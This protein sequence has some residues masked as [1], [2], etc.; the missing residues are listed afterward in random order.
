MRR[1][2]LLGAA[3]IAACNQGDAVNHTALHLDAYCTATVTGVGDV[4]VEN[5]YLP[6]VVMCENGGASFEALKAQAVAARSYLY[7]RLN[8]NGT[9]GDGT[10]DQVYT[11]SRQP[12][13]AQYMAVAATSGQVLGYMGTQVAAFYVAGSKQTP[14][15]CMGGTND[16]T[17]TEHFVT[18]NQGLSGDSIVQTT[19]G[20]V[21]PGN[22]A[23]RGCMS[24][25]GSDCLS[26]D[27]MVYDDILRFYYGE[28]IEIVQAQGACVT[29]PDG[30]D[31]GPGGGDG[32]VG[33]GDGGGGGGAGNG[34]LGGG[35]SGGGTTAP[36]L[37]LGVLALLF[38][39]RSSATAAA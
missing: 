30:P 9:I 7:Y 29:P 31:A 38:R 34:D 15:S 6:H 23:N 25:N 17:G 37:I 32:G 26:D 10:G 12:G 33:G 13:M 39:R 18:Y 20:F 2:L 8:G 16:P 36:W 14:P 4:D 21:S 28:D 5:D 22:Y 24:Q 11:C 3:L 27:G 19:L 1:S 35:C